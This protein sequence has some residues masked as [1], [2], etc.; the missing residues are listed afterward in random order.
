M[1]L[2]ATLRRL[3]D[4]HG[5]LSVLLNF[6]RLAHGYQPIFLDYKVE[7]VPRYGYGKPA[8]PELSRILARQ[9]C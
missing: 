6:Q 2:K 3:A 7:A 1:A 5:F 4:G 8:H 9:R